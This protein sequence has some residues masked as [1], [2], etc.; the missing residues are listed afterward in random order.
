MGRWTR[1]RAGGSSARR[2]CGQCLRAEATVGCDGVVA[3]EPWTLCNKPLC[4]ACATHVPAGA[5]FCKDCAR[6]RGLLPRE[7]GE[8]GD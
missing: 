3:K 2:G 7:P 1:R 4:P 8:E 6:T 5:D